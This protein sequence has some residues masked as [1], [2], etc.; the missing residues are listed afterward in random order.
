MKCSALYGTWRYMALFTK[1]CRWS[2]SWARWLHSTPWHPITARSLLIFP[3]TYVYVFMWLFSF[4][5]P[6]QNSVVYAVLFS[7]MCVTWPAYPIVLDSITAILLIEEGKLWSYSWDISLTLL[8]V[9]NLFTFINNE[10]I[11]N[12]VMTGYLCSHWYTKWKM[13][14]VFRIVISQ[15]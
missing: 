13:S 10:H 4:T 14:F 7:L 1:S 12:S 11:F 15:N 8:C 2:L 5:L 6:Y 9:A 3:P